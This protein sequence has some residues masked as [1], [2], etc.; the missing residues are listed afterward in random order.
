VNEHDSQN[1]EYRV[2]AFGILSFGDYESVD[3]TKDSIGLP[4]P[5]KQSAM[6]NSVLWERCAAQEAIR[7]DM[8]ELS[9][10][11]KIEDV[12]KRVK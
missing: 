9:L 12:L 2:L 10:K 8:L 11:R 1:G 7:N 4:S 6:H 3:L 5:E